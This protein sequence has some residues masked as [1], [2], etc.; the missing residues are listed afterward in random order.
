MMQLG[1]GPA[2]FTRTG[3]NL[4]RYLQHLTQLICSNMMPGEASSVQVNLGTTGMLE[5]LR[6]ARQRAFCARIA[7]VPLL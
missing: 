2:D 1:S 4:A 5:C 7:D 6:L 3:M